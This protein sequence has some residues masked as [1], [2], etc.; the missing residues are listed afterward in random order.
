MSAADSAGTSC[1][2]ALDEDFKGR[3]RQILFLFR[4]RLDLPVERQLMSVQ[5][6]MARAAA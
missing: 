3:S 6:R 1:E 5:V 4:Q 2:S